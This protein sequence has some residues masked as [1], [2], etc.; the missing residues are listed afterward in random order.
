[1]TRRIDPHGTSRIATPRPITPAYPPDLADFEALRRPHAW[2]EGDPALGAGSQLVVAALVL[3]GDDDVE[4][5]VA[6]VSAAIREAFAR[7]SEVQ[8]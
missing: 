8:P 3:H 2:F 1:M 7:V 5:N 6:A 4:A